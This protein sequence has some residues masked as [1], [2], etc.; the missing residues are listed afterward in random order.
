MHLAQFSQSQLT[1]SL[2]LPLTVPL[3]F[4]G[5]L[6][7]RSPYHRAIT[8]QNP[9]CTSVRAKTARSLVLRQGLNHSSMNG[10]SMEKN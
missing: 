1:P 7:P 5:V 9:S 3:L 8:G 2:T 6:H 4:Q 10:D